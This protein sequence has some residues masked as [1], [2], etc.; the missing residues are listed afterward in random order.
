MDGDNPVCFYIDDINKYR[1]DRMTED[2]KI[3]GPKLKWVQLVPDLCV[4]TV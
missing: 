3:N 2:E 1:T 4:G